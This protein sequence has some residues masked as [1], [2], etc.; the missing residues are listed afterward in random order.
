MA[1]GMELVLEFCE[2][3]PYGSASIHDCHGSA[4]FEC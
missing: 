1:D 2:Q 4:P 3:V